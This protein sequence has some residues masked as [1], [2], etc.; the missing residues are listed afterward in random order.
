[1]EYGTVF[2]DGRVVL[3]AEFGAAKVERDARVGVRGDRAGR[4]QVRAH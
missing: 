4:L 3:F 2:D 1:M